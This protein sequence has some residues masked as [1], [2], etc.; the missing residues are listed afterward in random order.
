MTMTHSTDGWP[1]AVQELRDLGGALPLGEAEDATWLFER[2]AT[3]ELRRAGAAVPGAT[4][5][6][7]RIDLL[8]PDTGGPLPVAAPPGA[9][10]PGPL[11]IDGEFAALPGESLPALA[12]QLRHAMFACAA[13]RLGLHVAEIN[14]RVTALLDPAD[15]SPVTS[16]PVEVPTASPDGEAAF[17]AAAVP[18]VAHLTR[19][20]GSPVTERRGRLRVEFATAAGH[21][22]L[23]V[24]RAVRAAVTATLTSGTTV[25]VLITAVNVTA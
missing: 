15:A 23:H 11:R 8:D 12:D 17:T 6:R 18:G 16:T 1:A 22:P 14:L 20:L 13:D 19:T 24:A 10:P 9:L 7:L 3:T 4:P 21:H 2:A 25:T 5:G